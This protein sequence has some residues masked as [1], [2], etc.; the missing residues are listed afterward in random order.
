MG[1]PEANWTWRPGHLASSY[2]GVAQR[3]W[4]QPT[5][6]GLLET[7]PHL[8]RRGG[9]LLKLLAHLSKP[10]FCP[11]LEGGKRTPVLLDLRVSAAECPVRVWVEMCLLLGRKLLWFSLLVHSAAPGK[12]IAQRP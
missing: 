3:A 8:C 6:P 7:Q 10:T 1:E 12:F 4:A 9:W 2:P 5:F 11:G